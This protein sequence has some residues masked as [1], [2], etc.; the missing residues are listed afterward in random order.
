MSYF[1]TRNVSTSLGFAMGWMYWYSLGIL[2][3]Y[4]ITAAALVIGYWPSDIHV[5]VWISIFCFVIIA[6]NVLPVKFYGETEFWFASIKVFAIIGLII[7]G[8]ILFFG[9]GPSKDPLYFRYWKDPGA[10][11]EW[12]V[13]GSA[14]TF[15]ALLGTLVGA[16]F[17]FG[18]APELLILT[19][20]EM[21]SP[22]RNLPIAA[23]TFFIRLLIFYIGGILVIGVICPSDA[24]ALTSGGKGA[25]ASP[26]VV[27]IAN[28]GISALP[29][30]INA[31]VI[32]SA[33][34]SG[35][36]FM[37][38]S[39]RSLYSMAVAGNAPAIFKKCTKA[40]LPYYAV[41]AT[42]IFIPLAYLSCASESAK[43]FNCKSYKS[44]T[45]DDMVY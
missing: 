31:V 17:P 41:A 23:N 27:G 21:V 7:L 42:S 36:S 43:V 20:G 4:E 8:I 3:P 39:S 29:S 14:G 16:A 40:G 33:W 28:A 32:T 5:A 15:C 13:T 9:G 25:G 22:R 18:F 30:V 44:V 38:M 37:Y 34:S 45:A 6:L 1:G 35:N 12:L 11:N 26:F 24:S 2:V 10:T 19:A